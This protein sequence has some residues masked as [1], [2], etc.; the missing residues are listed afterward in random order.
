[1]ITWNESRRGVTALM[2]IG[3]FAAVCLLLVMAGCDGGSTGGPSVSGP[4]PVVVAE[5]PATPN[6][7]PTYTAI[8]TPTPT[9]NVTPTLMPTSMPTP[10]PSAIPMPTPAATPMPSATPTHSTDESATDDCNESYYRIGRFYTPGSPPLWA[11]IS[12][13]PSWR[14]VDEAE[15]RSELEGWWGC[16]GDRLRM[17]EPYC[18]GPPSVVI[19]TGV[20]EL[21]LRTRGRRGCRD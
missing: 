18:T 19:R 6:P 13:I 16:H 8:I 3:M 10:M 21:L 5:T 20:I 14:E 15:L 4:E 12:S 7:S 2:Q 1:M 9:P 17:V 11:P